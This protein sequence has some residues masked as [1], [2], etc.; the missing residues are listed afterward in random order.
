MSDPAPVPAVLVSLELTSAVNEEGLAFC[1]IN[2]LLSDGQ[3]AIGQM[4]PEVIRG[5]AVAWIA[6]AEAARHDAALFGMLR[7]T[8]GLDL[9]E[10]AGFIQTLRKA[11]EAMDGPPERQEVDGE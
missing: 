11:R 6:G 5:L 8:M 9:D 1:Q 3:T 10:T 7:S 2:A 4:P